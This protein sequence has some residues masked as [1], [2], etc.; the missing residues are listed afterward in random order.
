MPS[1]FL[2]CCKD[3]DDDRE[4]YLGDA[5][6][7]NDGEIYDEVNCL[8]QSYPKYTKLQTFDKNG[9]KNI[10]LKNKTLIPS[11]LRQSFGPIEESE[12]DD[13]TKHKAKDKTNIMCATLYL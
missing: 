13:N 4:S 12:T 2:K 9:N 1:I 5:I 10:N 8:N 11:K 3:D 7:Y 6:E